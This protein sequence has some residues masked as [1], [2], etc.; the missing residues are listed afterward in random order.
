MD[1][2]KTG[3]LIRQL[4]TQA[5][6][7]Q[8]ALAERL[9]V[10]D[11]TVS[12]WETGGGCPDISL[13]GEVGNV[14]GVSMETLLGGEIIGQED[15]GNMKKLRFYVCPDCGNILTSTA[16]ARVQCC[17]RVLE[18]LTPRRAEETECLQMEVQ[19]GE[20]YITSDH[21][22]TKACYIAFAAFLTDSQLVMTRL[23]PEWGM[24]VRMPYFARGRLLWYSTAQGLL[25]KEVYVRRS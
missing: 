5:G 6:L 24:Q 9:H 17:G 11:K 22:M 7:T 1:P 4:R 12:K 15:T 10:T 25:Y 19:D 23:Y 20:W 2:I 16:D 21:P 13:L 14:L 18:P 8:R 3:R